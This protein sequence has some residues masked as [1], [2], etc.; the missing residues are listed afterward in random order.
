MGVNEDH[1]YVGQR[2]ETTQSSSLLDDMSQLNRILREQTREN[3]FLGTR[4]FDWKIILF[5][6]QVDNDR[7]NG[8]RPLGVLCSTGM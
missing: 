4:L 1:K 5:P 8:L 7:K 2:N 6:E 3:L